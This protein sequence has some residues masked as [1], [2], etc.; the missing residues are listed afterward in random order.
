[1]IDEHEPCR[2]LVPARKAI[3]AP[4]RAFGGLPA[5]E[6]GVRTG[7]INSPLQGLSPE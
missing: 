3:L 2:K 5:D 7:G 1:M 4:V 6:T